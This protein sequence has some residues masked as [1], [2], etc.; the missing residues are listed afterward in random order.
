MISIMKDRDPKNEFI[1]YIEEVEYNKIQNF[2][3]SHDGIIFASSCENMPNILIESMGSGL[4]IACSDKQPMP[5]FLK[6]GGYYFN[7]NSVD[8]IKKA[9]INLIEDKDSSKKIK[10][11]LN[12]IRNLKWE[13]TSKK[14]FNFIIKL[15][16]QYV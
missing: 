7:A 16:K 12:E 6:D 14:T 5:E 2:Y 9:I 4:P 15:T 3:S 10:Q 11:N 1:S 13:E 8:S